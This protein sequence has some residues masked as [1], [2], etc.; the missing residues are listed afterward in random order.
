[1]L[2]SWMEWG[3]N[4]T[5]QEMIERTLLHESPS[6]LAIQGI[7]NARL[8]I[9]GDKLYEITNNPEENPETLSGLAEELGYRAVIN[10]KQDPVHCFDIVFY[11]GEELVH[12]VEQDR[13]NDHLLSLENWLTYAN[14]PQTIKIQQGILIDL[15][16]KVKEILPDYM[17]PANWYFIEEMPLT[18]HGKIDDKFLRSLRLE[19]ANYLFNPPTTETE[20]QLCLLWDSC[21]D[22]NNL[23]IDDNFFENGGES[24][25]AVELISKINETFNLDLPVKV[26]MDFP[27]IKALGTVIEKKQLGEKEVTSSS[28]INSVVTLKKGSND[29][30]PLFLIHPVGGMVFCYKALIEQLNFNGAC[31]ALQDPS[32]GAKKLIFSS[33]KEM[34]ASYIECIKH[35]QPKGSYKLAGHSFGGTVA[36]EIARQLMEMKEEVQFV[37]LFDTWARAINKEKLHHQ[38]K[39]SLVKEYES[40]KRKEYSAKLFRAGPIIDLS[41]WIKLGADRMNLSLNYQVPRNLNFP[42]ILFKAEETSNKTIGEQASLTNY[43]DKIPMLAG[44]PFYWIFI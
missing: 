1:M 25:R 27:T 42:I 5:T 30:L 44:L 38:V 40:T 4:F 31:Y 21:L 29:E 35:F 22:I 14:Q 17:I 3:K 10:C 43:W 2:V 18:P 19:K 7:P 36:I 34:A 16:E 32:I 13:R 9:S 23:G 37:V 28:L 33:I 39:E 26:I 6:H 41:F 24:L 12:I 15:K 20:K 8:P 11:R